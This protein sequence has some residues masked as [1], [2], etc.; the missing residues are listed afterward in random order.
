M[1]DIIEGRDE[2]AIELCETL[3]LTCAE[4]SSTDVFCFF[5]LYLYLLSIPYT[6]MARD[7]LRFII[8]TINQTRHT[9]SREIWRHNVCIYMYSNSLTFFLFTLIY[10]GD[11]RFLHPIRPLF[12]NIPVAR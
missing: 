6:F 3:L 8:Q 2:K 1:E 12:L 5:F 7:L 9:T 10:R 4:Q 11:V